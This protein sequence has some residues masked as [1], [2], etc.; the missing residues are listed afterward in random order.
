MLIMTQIKF[1]DKLEYDFIRCPI[2]K[3]K[4]GW[5]RKETKVRVI[6]TQNNTEYDDIEGI[7][8]FCNKCN[9]YHLITIGK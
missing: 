3:N 4:L 6:A 9:T 1:F 7:V 8:I 2:S 5:K